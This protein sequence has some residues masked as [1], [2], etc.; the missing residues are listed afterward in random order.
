M[1]ADSNAQITLTNL[2]ILEPTQNIEHLYPALWEILEASV[3]NG[4]DTSTSKNCP[5]GRN[6]HRA[7]NITG[8][9]PSSDLS[10]IKQKQE[11]ISLNHDLPRICV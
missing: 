2:N 1:E 5:A 8:A 7:S 10:N 6:A 11:G 3:V 4:K 9:I